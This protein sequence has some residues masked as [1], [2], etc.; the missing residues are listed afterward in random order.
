MRQCS[1]AALT[2]FFGKCRSII[3]PR[4]PK[5]T[6][7][8]FSPS[9]PPFCFSMAPVDPS[10]ENP[11]ED[12]VQ[13]PQFVLASSVL[14]WCDSGTRFS[15]YGSLNTRLWETYTGLQLWSTDHNCLFSRALKLAGLILGVV[16]KEEEIMS[17]TPAPT[18]V[19]PYPAVERGRVM[20]VAVSL[21]RRGDVVQRICW[22]LMRV[23]REARF[24]L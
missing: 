13:E 22:I 11:G 3:S 14:T 7:T 23:A 18:P 1:N 20:T 9:W 15:K 17:P 5:G 6:K 2:H 4:G 8:R 10:V 19:Q 21:R 16:E 24:L 12:I